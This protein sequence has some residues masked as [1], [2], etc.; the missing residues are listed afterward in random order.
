MSPFWLA[1][2]ALMLATAA[3]AQT[4]SIHSESLPPLQQQWQEE[5]SSPV[6]QAPVQQA[7]VGPD[8][9]NQG[10]QAPSAPP[11]VA[12][13]PPAT[14]ERPNTWLSGSVVKLEALDKVA[15]QSAAL[16]IKV[17]DS[18]TF[19]S[20]TIVAK[21][22]VVRPTDQPADAAALLVVTDSH[23]D[24]G[25]FSGWMLEDEPS[26]S[27]MENPIYDLRVTGCT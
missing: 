19:G 23:P 2:P 10:Q 27:M 13:T 15:A 24:S 17:G 25:G 7:P 9:T 14:M 3:Q 4:A 26:V 8:A 11:S 16:T 6:Q 22:C 12:A 1:V 21:A 5:G 20:L 18:V